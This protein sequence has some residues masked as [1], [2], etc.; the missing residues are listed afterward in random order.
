MAYAELTHTVLSP[1]AP[2][3]FRIF[4]INM[5]ALAIS[6]TLPGGTVPGTAA[7]YRLLT[8]SDVSGSTAAF[9]LATQGIGSAVVL[10]LIFW[11]SLLISIPLQGYNPLY[12]FAAILGVLLL[13]IFAARGLPPDPGRE[14]GRRLREEGGRPPALR[15]GRDRDLAGPEGG[16]PDEDPVHELGAAH[17]GRHLGGGQL[18]A[19]RRLAWVFLLAFGAHVSPID[20]LV[21]YGLANILA[22]IPLTPSGLG[23]IELTIIAVLKGFGVP[24]GV[25]AAGVLSWRLVNFWLPIPFGGAAYL[26]LRFGRPRAHGGGQGDPVLTR[27]RLM[28]VARRPSLTARWVAAQ[29]L[30]LGAHAAVHA[31]RRRRG[32]APPLPRRRRH[33]RRSRSAVPPAIAQRTRV[34]DAEV[35]RAIGRG[36]TQIVLLGAG[37]DG[38]ALRFGGGAVRWFEVD[39]PR[40]R[41]TSAAGST[42]SASR[43]PATSP[44]SPLDLDGRTDLGAALDGG[45]TRRAPRRRS[46]S[47]RA[48]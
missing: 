26:S 18:A 11:L 15:A 39:R 27:Y 5:W 28:R 8:E 6:H 7:S 1:G 25:A 14:A 30:R 4:R 48:C 44:T 20:V 16:G 36:T 47:A 37:Y 23:V 32:G 46:S 45:R 35:A 9:G 43:P 19:R 29:R 17:A 21:A 2:D 24:G 40:P 12:G 3:R 42:R 38:R 41:P 33:V 22:V 10:N 34:V 13:A 31:R